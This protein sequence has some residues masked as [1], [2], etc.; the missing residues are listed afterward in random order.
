ML[1]HG[2]TTEKVKPREKSTVAAML[3]VPLAEVEKLLQ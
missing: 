2:D 3:S 1:V